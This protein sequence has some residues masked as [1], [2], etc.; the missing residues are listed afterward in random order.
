M[1]NKELAEKDSI[2]RKKLYQKE[3]EK[4]NFNSPKSNFYFNAEEVFNIPVVV[5]IIHLGESVGNGTNIS[6]AHK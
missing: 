5:H 6:D 2:F 4:I 3:A 1:L